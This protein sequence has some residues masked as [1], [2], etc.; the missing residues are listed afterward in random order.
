MSQWVKLDMIQ[1]IASRTNQGKITGIVWPEP[2]K[3]YHPKH[4]VLE[5]MGCLQRKA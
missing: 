1:Y 2:H 4:I 3:M 5:V